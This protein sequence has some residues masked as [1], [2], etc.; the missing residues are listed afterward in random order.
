MVS[1]ETLKISYSFCMNTWIVSSGCRNYSRV[2]I[3]QGRKLFAE[4]PYYVFV[5][6]EVFFRKFSGMVI[7]KEWFVMK[8]GLWWCTYSIK[9]QCGYQ[10][11]ANWKNSYIQCSNDKLSTLLNT[12]IT[13]LSI[14]KW[15]I[16]FTK[17][18]FHI[19][20]LSFMPLGNH[21]ATDTK[22]D[23]ITTVVSIFAGLNCEKWI[24]ELNG[25]L[26]KIPP[27]RSMNCFLRKLH[28]RRNYC[29]QF[30]LSVSHTHNPLSYT[31]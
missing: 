25:K 2:K 28:H 24:E 21:Q 22:K 4:I 9:K 19:A 13:S 5:F 1:S 30:F 15:I 16:Y 18:F 11:C 23:E 6:K 20:T 14:K 27:N 8:S 31:Q 26:S 7:I 12:F 17:R 10:T 3:F 29:A